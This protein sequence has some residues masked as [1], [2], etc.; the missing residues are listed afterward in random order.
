M[1]KK[2]EW[3]DKMMI[4]VT[5]AECGALDSIKEITSKELNIKEATSDVLVASENKTIKQKKLSA[6]ARFANLIKSF[7]DTM[8]AT[9]FAEAGENIEAYKIYHHGRNTRRKILL[10]TDSRELDINTIGYALKLCQRVE[11]GLEILHVIQNE[12]ENDCTGQKETCAT[13]GQ[14]QTLLGEIGIDYTPVES[15]GSFQNELIDHVAGRNNI[16]CVVVNRDARNQEKESL[17]KKMTALAK[18]FGKI[19]CP[20]VVYEQPI[21][22]I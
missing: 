1:K 18:A 19:N 6:A 12:K 14:L 22:A 7:E 15:K 17:K 20:L 21:A 4:A 9:S 16:M 10:G 11:A 2:L 5:Y 3:L 8:T 13:P